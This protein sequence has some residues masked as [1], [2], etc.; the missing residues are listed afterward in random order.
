MDHGRWHQ[1]VSVAICALFLDGHPAIAQDQMPGRQWLTR[2]EEGWFWYKDPPAEPEEGAKPPPPA[3]PPTPPTPPPVAPVAAPAAPKAPPEP[4]PLSAAWFRQ[5][6][7]GYRDAALDNPTVDNV[8]RYLILQCVMM[9]KSSAF[10]E[11]FQQVVATN[12]ILDANSER[13]LD[14]IGA[15]VA[16]EMASTASTAVLRAL[17]ET[18]GLVYFFRSDCAL[19]VPEFAVLEAAQ[20]VYGFNVLYVSLDGRPIPNVRLPSWVADAGQAER[21]GVGAAPSLVLMRPPG[22]FLLISDS[23]MGLPTI[24]ERVLLRARMAG[25]ITEEAYQASR[26]VRNRSLLPLAAGIT[27]EMLSDPAKLAA[28]VDTQVGGVAR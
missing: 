8:R 2:G 13:P 7:D 28:F 20:R 11:A 14:S 22:E 6:L 12:P 4:A 3:S 27:P 25:W 16:N 23:V 5:N 19:C 1:L 10:T 9:D 18:V 17:A 15:N 21:M 26:P 24:A